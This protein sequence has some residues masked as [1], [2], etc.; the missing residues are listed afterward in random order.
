[1]SVFEP[2]V[3]LNLL[4]N[5]AAVSPIDKSA[6]EKSWTVNVEKRVSIWKESRNHKTHPRPEFQLRWEA[7]VVE[8]V[9]CLWEKSRPRSKKIEPTHKLGLNIPL[10][11]PRFVP[12]SYIHIQKRSGLGHQ[13]IEPVTQYIKPFNVIHP[14][15]YPQLATCPRCSSDEETTWEGWTSTGPRELHGLICE[16]TALGAQLRCNTCKEST[17]MKKAADKNI[18]GDVEDVQA[19]QPANLEGY[20]FAT[21]SAA[22]WS[23]WEHWRIPREF[24]AL[25]V[26]SIHSPNEQAASQSFSIAVP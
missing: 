8:Y 26:W 21:T 16:E 22:Y 4:K 11:G 1:M 2:K 24:R 23:S 9:Q 10:L 18:P 20:C 12:P 5:S 13:D 6:F 25:D 14:F 7:E 15:Y 3:V 17:K 19:H